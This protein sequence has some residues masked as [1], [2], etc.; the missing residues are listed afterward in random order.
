MG[1]PVVC[2]V[3]AAVIF[4][5]GWK[6]DTKGLQNIEDTLSERRAAKLTQSK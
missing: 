3:I 2:F 1:I 4:G 5:F 6:L